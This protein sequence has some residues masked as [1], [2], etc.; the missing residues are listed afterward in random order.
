[1]SVELLALTVRSPHVLE[2]VQV[3]HEYAEGELSAQEHFFRSHMRRPGYAGLLAKVDDKIVGLAFG[4]TSM[5]G[6]WWHE[7]VAS[8][9]GHEHPALQ[10]AWVLTQLNV[11]RAYRNRKIGATLH[12]A[13]IAKQRHM[14]LLLSTQVS[15]RG[16]QRFYQ[17]HGWQCLHAG[18]KFSAS[19]EPYQIWHK[20]L[21]TP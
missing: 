3:Y 15:N 14:R 4:S 5:P 17:Q 2:A 21:S 18:F 9:V 20:T 16:A 8:Q 13:L 11:L 19:D 12:D 10:D 6:Q 7:R 1:M